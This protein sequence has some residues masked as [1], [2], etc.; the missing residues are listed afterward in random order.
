MSGVVE[1]LCS[2]MVCFFFPFFAENYIV[3]LLAPK[4]S[5]ISYKLFLSW[6]ILVDLLFVMLLRRRESPKMIR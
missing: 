3:P 2:E 1:K 4:R 6:R 5:I